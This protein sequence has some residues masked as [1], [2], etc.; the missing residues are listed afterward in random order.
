MIENFHFRF[1]KILV[2]NGKNE[3]MQKEELCIL[4]QFTNEL[5]FLFI[6]L[7]NAKKINSK[8]FLEIENS[9]SKA[10]NFLKIT[11]S[12]TCL[13][14]KE[15]MKDLTGIMKPFCRNFILS[16]IEEVFKIRK[17][18]KTKPKNLKMAILFFKLF[19]LNLILSLKLNRNRCIN[20]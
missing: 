5:S 11:Y 3:D 20:F 10:T 19:F 6:S 2:H 18:Q 9:F 1:N 13:W 16:S 8:H 14:K 17:K 7:E 12:Y 4:E 15:F